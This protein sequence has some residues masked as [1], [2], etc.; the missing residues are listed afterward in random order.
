MSISK[1]TDE[2]IGQL[3][4]IKVMGWKYND[5]LCGW[6]TNGINTTLGDVV[7]KR[8]WNPCQR[9]DQAFRV[10]DKMQDDDFWF[11]MTYKECASPETR[12]A[13]YQVVFR[14]VRGGTRGDHIAANDNPSRAIC[15]AALKAVE[16][17]EALT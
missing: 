1:M 17:R 5:P 7:G 9:I 3:V 8:E 14:C 4:A 2:E 13:M 12:S 11:S 16:L 10:V 15:E 6:I